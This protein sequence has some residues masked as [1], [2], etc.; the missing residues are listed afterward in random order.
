M[1]EDTGAPG[2]GAAIVAVG[3]G[4]GGVAVMLLVWLATAPHGIGGYQD[5]VLYTYT[6]ASLLEGRGLEVQPGMPLTLWPPLYPASL[7]AFGAMGFD[8]VTAARTL[9]ALSLG[10]SVPLCA[11]L[12]RASRRS[13]GAVLVCILWVALGHPLLF[14]AAQ[15]TAEPLFILLAL[16]TL[17]GIVEFRR[18]GHPAWFGV[19]VLG[20]ALACVERYMGVAVVGTGALVLLA[21]TAGT[22]ARRRFLQASGFLLL[23]LVPLTLWLIRN[24]LVSGM[25]TGLR[26]PPERTLLQD[27]ALAAGAMGEWCML[28]PPLVQ[29]AIGTGVLSL[30]MV[31]VWRSW[32]HGTGAATL[33]PP[34]A[35]LMFMALLLVVSRLASY[36][37]IRMRLASPGY[38]FAVLTLVG[39]A[40]E[41]V[42]WVGARFH[43]SRTCRAGA[44]VLAAVWLTY[45]VSQS[46]A[47]LRQYRAEGPPGV[48]MINYFVPGAT[49]PGTAEPGGA[50]PTSGA[51]G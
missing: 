45:P 18:R 6:A 22:G 47:M 13:V 39:L 37:P 1:T 15:V 50:P 33:V 25:W 44:L 19:A 21:P 27:A 5:S 10:L 7:A 26:F 49:G 29:C 41:A 34:L 9:N 17:A 46:A 2:R 3:A 38:V 32:R 24:Y 30:A 23:S 8:P 51:P 20:A 31:A 4:L 16:V 42:A 43:M 35:V 48:Y 28:G 11:A 40:D 14:V 36:N 12:C